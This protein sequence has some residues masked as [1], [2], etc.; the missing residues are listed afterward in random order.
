MKNLGDYT[1]GDQFIQDKS[2]E[3]ESVKATVQNEVESL[4]IIP[5]TQASSSVS[6]VT[7]NVIDLTLP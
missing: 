5:V 6:T 2:P 7:S 1:Y 3:A 4:I